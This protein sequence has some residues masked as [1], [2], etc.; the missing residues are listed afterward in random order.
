MKIVK[1]EHHSAE[2]LIERLH[3]VTLM[4]Q[5]EELIY[6]NSL[7]SLEK[8]R[9]DLIVPA[10][11]YVLSSELKKIRDLKWAIEEHGYNI[12]ELN[13]YLSIWLEGEEEP[14]DLMPPVIEESI[15]ADGRLVPI[16]NDGMHRVYLALL[17]WQIP[18]VIFVRGIPK[19][20]PYYAFPIQEGWNFVKIVEDLPPG[21][22]KKWHRIK[23][24]KTL[25]R[26]FNSAFQN[27]GGP[28]GNF[29]KK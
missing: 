27:V 8:M 18:Q 23:E 20:K 16:L 6:K 22:I 29:V 26:D 7:I 11:H 17:E 13:G 28:R 3:K 24:Y 10:Q 4:K 21:F 12:F 5:P 25:Y 2:E 19:E 14:I 9:V 1:I 15:E